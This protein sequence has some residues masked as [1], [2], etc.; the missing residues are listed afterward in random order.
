MPDLFGNKLPGEQGGGGRDLFGNPLPG[1]SAPQ[2]PGFLSSIPG[3]QTAL[4]IL[5]PALDF[6]SRGQYA[7]AGFFDALINDNASVLDALSQAGN[8]LISPTKRKS[9]SDVISRANPDFATNNPTATKVLGFLGDIALDPTTYLGLGLG[10]ATKGARIG[11]RALTTLGEAYQTAARGALAGKTVALG[12]PGATYAAAETLGR[13]SLSRLPGKIAAGA[14]F[15]RAEAAATLFDEATADI[16]RSV[17]ASIGK[18]LRTMLGGKLP[19]GVTDEA[20]DALASRISLERLGIPNT[21][22]AVNFVTRQLDTQEI[23]DTADHM[24]GRLAELSPEL[25]RQLFKPGGLRLSIGI[26]LTR[27]Q[28]EIPI[29]NRDILRAVGLDRL[30]GVVKAVAALPGIKQALRGGEVLRGAFDRFYKLPDDYVR[31]ITKLQDEY[32]FLQSDVVRD[33]RILVNDIPREGRERISRVMNGFQAGIETLSDE[34]RLNQAPQ[35]FQMA[36]RQARLEPKEQAVVMSLIQGYGRAA[37]LERAALVAGQSAANFDPRVYQ[38]ISENADEAAEWMRRASADGVNTVGLTATETGKAA[39]LAAAIADGADINQDAVLLYAAR[40]IQA[41][42]RVSKLQAN[43]AIKAIFGTT[44]L[45]GLPKRVAADL[46]YFGDYHLPTFADEEGNAILSTIDRVQRLWKAS[47][48]VINPSFAPKQALQNS[49]QATL[50]M[51]NNAW[52]AFD[53][54]AYSAAAH[55][56][57]GRTARTRE[58]LPET[59]AEWLRKFTDADQV[60]LAGQLATRNLSKADEAL[61]LGRGLEITTATGQKFT[62]EEIELMAEQNGI[63]RGT[64][65]FSGEMLKRSLQE[66]IGLGRPENFTGKAWEATK[67]LANGYLGLSSKV[68]DTSRL[69]LFVN[70]LTMGDSPVQAAQRVNRAL[71]DYGRSFSRFETE[72]VKRLIPFYSFQRLAVP[73]VLR[74]TLENPGS[75]ATL[76]KVADLAGRLISGDKDGQ[77]ATLSQADREIFGRSFLVEQPRVFKG[78]DTEGNALFNVF[79]NL[80]PFDVLSI[81]TVTKGKNGEIDWLRTA[82]KT[83]GGMLTPFLK[84]PAEVVA[85]RDFFKDEVIKDARGYGGAGKLGKIKDKALDQVIPEPIKQM[86]GWEWGKDRK[87]GEPVAYVNPY[88]AYTMAQLAPPVAQ[89]FFKPFGDDESVIERAMRMTLGIGEKSLDIKQQREFQNAE[90]KRTLQEMRQKVVAAQ[91]TGRKNSLEQALA[92]YRQI[93]QAVAERRRQ[94]ASIQAVEPDQGGTE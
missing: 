92:D 28:A 44:D 67:A 23:A 68:E 30:D 8:E 16:A 14:K 77:P 29:V 94:A 50:V 49:L 38:A 43:G 79:N 61:D 46:R 47:K 81:F 6:L 40:V 24:I 1:G 87:T 71:F 82:E 66:E 36:L 42:Q 53:P 73:L 51:G 18:D 26:P 2:S 27:A 93:L 3:A 72:V 9:F 48:T 52:R 22:Q 15:E 80:T 58:G 4:S 70:A 7:S 86:I 88:L 25:G 13:E 63:I 57:F 5:A 32:S 41:R 39:D 78:F 31:T 60:E 74:T 65:G 12:L 11:G 64:S 90:D 35:V 34:Q 59:A 56:L 33:A 19:A 45:T 85:N 91:R 17:S 55:I 89:Q 37:E 76:N 10:A 54:R 20:L 75:A 83:I 62:R 69:A 21:K 84:I